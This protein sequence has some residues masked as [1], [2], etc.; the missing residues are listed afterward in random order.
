[1][2]QIRDKGV[3]EFFSEL[4]KIK[5]SNPES[6]HFII[7]N[8]LNHLPHWDHLVDNKPFFDCLARISHYDEQKYACIK[9]FLKYTGSSQH[10]LVKTIHAFEVFWSE[11][12]QL[13]AEQKIPLSQFKDNWQFPRQGNPLVYMERMLCILKNAR[14]LDDQF[15]V[16]RG[17]EL[18]QYE[19]FTLA[20]T[21]VINPFV[22]KWSFI[23]TVKKKINAL[24][25]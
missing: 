8:C 11:L 6:M 14:S 5:D 22:K 16:M 17:L 7:R 20:N 13:C 3:R 10:D 25:I 2:D 9:Q 21:K 15:K 4:Q 18:N 19:P 1:M 12:T 23:T 24:L